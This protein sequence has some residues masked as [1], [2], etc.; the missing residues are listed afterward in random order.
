MSFCPKCFPCVQDV[1]AYRVFFCLGCIRLQSIL[2]SRIY[3]PTG[4][5]SVQMYLLVGYPSVQDVSVFRVSVCPGCICLQGFLLSG[6]YLHRG[7]PFVRDVSAYRVSFCPECICLQGF[8]LPR[9]CLPTGFPSARSIFLPTVFFLP[10]VSACLQCF[11]V[12]V[13]FSFGTGFFYPFLPLV[14]LLGLGVMF[15]EYLMFQRE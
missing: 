14:V 6:M 13:V 10:T 7:F 5:S 12:P 8:L 3:L 11:P 1:S 15:V 9:V 4:F 2:L